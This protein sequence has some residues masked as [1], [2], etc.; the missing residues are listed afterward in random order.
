MRS[1]FSIGCST[2]VMHTCNQEVPQ[3][4]TA[5]V[6]CWQS[7]DQSDDLVFAKTV[8]W[9]T[10]CLIK[11][12][13]DPEL[14]IKN[15][16]LKVGVFSKWCQNLYCILAWELAKLKSEILI[17]RRVKLF[18]ALSLR[19]ICSVGKSFQEMPNWCYVWSSYIWSLNSREELS[20]VLVSWILQSLLEL[21]GR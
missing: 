12:F 21:S 3:I 2:V 13:P 10:D 18:L 15:W 1:E 16:K 9:W 8:N 4:L 7:A 19:G 14:I 6:V 17:Y 11:S 5:L 20:P